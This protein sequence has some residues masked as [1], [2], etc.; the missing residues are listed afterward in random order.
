[1]KIQKN[2]THADRQKVYRERHT[3]SYR[4]K[5]ADRMRAF[6]KAHIPSFVGV[7]SEGIGRGKN[8]RAVLL[9]C[10][11]RHIIAADMRRGLQWE[12]IFEFLYYDNFEQNP[13]DTVYVGF[14][15]KYDFNEWLR[16]LPVNKARSLL[17]PEGKEKRRIKKGPRQRY[18]RGGQS[19]PVRIDRWEID[20]PAGWRCLQIRPRVCECL[21]LEIKCTHTQKPWLVICDAGPFFQSSFLK[22][23]KEWPEAERLWTQKEFDTVKFG[24]ENLRTV[25]RFSK[26]MIE[27]NRLENDILARIM[28]QVAEGLRDMGIKLSRDQWY[29]PGPVAASWLSQNGG[30]K[31]RDLLE[32]PGLEDWLTTCR[33]SFYGGWFEIFS[34]G[35]I[36]GKSYNYDINSAYPY[37]TTKLPH[38]CDQCSIVS[39]NGCPEN[40]TSFMLLHC[41]VRSKGDR[42]GAMPHRDSHGSI[43]RPNITK[44]WYWSN[45]LDAANAAGLI[46]DIEYH[47]YM[48][49]R[50]CNHPEPFLAIGDLYAQRNAVGKD[51]PRGRAI[52]LVINSVYGKFA[53]SVGAKP[54]NN[55]FYASYITSHCRTQ[56]LNAIAT[57]PCKSEGVLM[58][59]TDGICFDSLHP[60]L[61]V[62]A[63]KILGEWD[64][65][66]YDN[67]VLFKPGVYWDSKGKADL[68]IKS[69]G[70]PA[71]EFAK[72]IDQ[73]EAMFQ[74]IQTKKW[75]PTSPIM[76]SWVSN[77]LCTNE[78]DSSVPEYFLG[79]YGWP[80]YV[81]HLPFHMVSCAQALQR[82]KWEIAGDMQEDYPMIQSSFPFLKRGDLKWKG[83]RL[84]STLRV[85]D[86]SDVQTMYYKDPSIKYPKKIDLGFGIDGDAFDAI[87]EVVSIARD[88][89]P[90]YD[91]DLDEIEWE[92]VW[93][94]GPV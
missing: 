14:Y 84:D 67:L 10:G 17:S 45:E 48:E 35:I 87:L 3:D 22:V 43:F 36:P 16:S 25:T 38:I 4:Q 82:G 80:Q 90:S 77:N 50:P 53:Q 2:Y 21:E 69:R 5:N 78:G 11:Q 83:G 72:G 81:V 57:H 32:I 75:W 27:Y 65:S 70:V 1:M 34:H 64:L 13:E 23:L 86:K 15:L 7:D 71:M 56:I 28:T 74:Q 68:K 39:G 33:Y 6:R 44:G 42:I 29:G 49:I 79:P 30:I 89:K 73:I 46:K 40:R 62:S 26:K 24:K 91:I 61:P 63:E 85:L 37:A 47:E 19:Y 88:K 18:R 55:W 9:G 54:Y 41:T 93:N 20:M 8:H 52:K 92:T 58:V 12:E 94:G 66:E 31:H 60:T 51:S 76:H 59:A